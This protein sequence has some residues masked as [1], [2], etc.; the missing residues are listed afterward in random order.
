MLIALGIVL[1]V[2]RNFAVNL[3]FIF[4]CTINT[5]NFSIKKLLVIFDRFSN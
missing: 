2:N 4:V 1:N 5:Y 3:V